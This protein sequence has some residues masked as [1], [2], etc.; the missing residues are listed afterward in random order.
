LQAEQQS[1]FWEIGAFHQGKDDVNLTVVSVNVGIWDKLTRLIMM[2]IVLAFGLGV[3]FWYMPLIQQNERMSQE[4][5]Q[6]EQAI[7]REKQ[8]S[9]ELKS[10]IE[11]VLHDPKTVE[12]LAREKLG[13]A[14]PGETIIRFEP[15]ADSSSNRSDGNDR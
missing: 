8:K 6:L 1:D 13:Y 10:T 2:L 14:L 4:I 9:R 5:L 11:A 7:Q 3:I 15:P 12:R